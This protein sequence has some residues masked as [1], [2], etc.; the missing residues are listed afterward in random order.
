M[1]NMNGYSGFFYK[2]IFNNFMFGE[3][4]NNSYTGNRSRYVDV[5]QTPFDFNGDGITLPSDPAYQAFT[6]QGTTIFNYSPKTAPSV[7]VVSSSV[8]NT[9]SLTWPTA[10]QDWGIVTFMMVSHSFSNN[11][12]YGNPVGI[13]PLFGGQLDADAWVQTGDTLICLALDFTLTYVW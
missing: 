3:P 5:S 8:W 12:G 7:G 2:Y 4:P 10:T 11:P 1:S 6:G 13:Y 9:L